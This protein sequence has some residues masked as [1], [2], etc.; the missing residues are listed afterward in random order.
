MPLKVNKVK[1]LHNAI[2]DN[3]NILKEVDNLI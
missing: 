3:R 1:Y 2:N